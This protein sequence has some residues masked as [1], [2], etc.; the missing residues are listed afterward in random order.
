MVKEG[1][2]S[3]PRGPG[4]EGS[5][6]EGVGRFETSRLVMVVLK[7]ARVVV[8]QRGIS[9]SPRRRA[10]RAFWSQVAGL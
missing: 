3:V 6:G 4:V 1:G 8:V 9:S 5:E 7:S 2:V 10:G